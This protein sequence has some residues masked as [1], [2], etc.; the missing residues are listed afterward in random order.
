MHTF[1][2]LLALL[3][4]VRIMAILNA[5]AADDNCVVCAVQVWVGDLWL[6]REDDRVCGQPQG[7]MGVARGEHEGVAAAPAAQSSGQG[8]WRGLHADVKAEKQ[9]L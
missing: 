5:A 2:F 6:L 4:R 8:H 9:H 3:L 7:G 1:A